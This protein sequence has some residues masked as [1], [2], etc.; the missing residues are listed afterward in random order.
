[1]EALLNHGISEI[2]WP[3]PPF[4]PDQCWRDLGAIQSRHC[5]RGIREPERGSDFPKV[6]LRLDGRIVIGDRSLTPP[7]ILTVFS[8]PFSSPAS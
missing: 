2:A 5:I 3:Q 8:I 1:M 4:H 7:D 6:T